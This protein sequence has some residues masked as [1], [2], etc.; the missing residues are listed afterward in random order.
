MDTIDQDT[1]STDQ[2][3]RVQKRRSYSLEL[4]RQIVQEALD[5]SASVSVVARRYDINTNQLFRW[6][7]QYREGL[8]RDEPPPQSLVP[9]EISQS[10]Q[11]L[12]MVSAPAVAGHRSEAGSLEVTLANG[13]QVV[14]TGAVCLVTLQAVLEA[15][16][17]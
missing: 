8:L 14:V 16:S 1:E 15:L 2:A 5:G 10:R 7:R 17:A 3:T 4:K 9:I 6:R 13:H 11:E 12:P